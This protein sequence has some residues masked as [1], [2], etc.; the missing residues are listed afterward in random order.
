MDTAFVYLA[1]QEIL[2][3]FLLVGVGTLVGRVRLA[4]VSLGAAAVL[5][6]AIALSA[7]G[8]S[9]G[10]HLVVPE[11]LGTLGLTLFTFAIGVMSGPGFFASLR[12]GVWP[13]LATVGVLSTAAL[14][15]VLAGRLLGLDPALVAGTFAGAVTNTPALAAAREAAGDSPLPTIGYAVSYIFGVLGMLLATHFALRDRARDADAPTPLVNCSVRVET[16]EEPGIREIERR[17]EGRIRFSRVKHGGS[18]FPS[19]TPADDDVLRRNDLVTVVGPE[20]LVASVVAELGHTSSHTL[21]ADRSE[22][23]FRRITLSNGQLAGNTIAGLGLTARFGAT[24][25]RVRRGDVDMLAADELV[26]Q[27]GDRVRV[28]A[29]RAKMA[30]VSSFLGDS[31]RGLSDINPVA[32]GL[33]MALGI[34][35]GKFVFPVPG[36]EFSI[37]SAAGTLVLGLVFGQLC[38]VGPIVT[39]MPHMAAQAIAELGLLIFLAQAGTKAGGQLGVAFASGAWID[40]LILGAVVTCTVAAGSWLVMRRVFKMGCT[41]LAGV[42]AGTQTQPAVLAF[43]NGRTGHDSRVAQ[44]YA[45]VYP[46]AMITK[47]L[48]GQLLGGL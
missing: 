15:A 34:L 21:H 2:L 23:D 13:I 26:L 31:E 46:A 43:A 11:A 4:G 47:I 3:L 42:M 37:G 32:L 29:P 40:I 36:V 25:T 16:S 18:R 27:P 30:A 35:L 39:T 22:L 20:D 33:G 45:L 1:R 38:R 24:I 8:Q 9:R 5:F 41:R 12:R 44:G 48:L 10:H 17:Y 14:V 6:V 19:Q 7:W 28:T